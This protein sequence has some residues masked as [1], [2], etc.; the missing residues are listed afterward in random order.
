MRISTTFKSNDRIQGSHDPDNHTIFIH[1][2]DSLLN[3]SMSE[4]IVLE[5]IVQQ[6]MERVTRALNEQNKALSPDSKD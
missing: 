6:E 5:R 2:G 3:I 4:A 1:L